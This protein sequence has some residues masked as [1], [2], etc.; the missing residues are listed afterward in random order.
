MGKAHE[1]GTFSK[2]EAH[3]PYTPLFWV[4]PYYPGTF[5]PHIISFY[6]YLVQHPLLSRQCQ[7]ARLWG[8]KKVQGKEFN[9][10]NLWN[11]MLIHSSH[12]GFHLRILWCSQSGNRSQNNL[13]K[14]GYT[15]DMEVGRKKKILLYSWL[16][17]GTYHKNLAIWKKIPQTHHPHFPVMR[18][19]SWMKPPFS[20]GVGFFCV[21]WGVPCPL[22]L[23]ALSWP[24][25][26]PTC[27][28]SDLIPPTPTE[29]PPTY[30]PTN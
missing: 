13:A 29:S 11:A 16:S 26:L 19:S 23:P 24:R 9:Q 2:C 20:P 3:P 1:W 10:L 12:P 15:L 22:G 14:F 28:P 18:P 21:F 5:T 7:G 17:T 8:I 4:C 25:Y 27:D 6:R 30:L